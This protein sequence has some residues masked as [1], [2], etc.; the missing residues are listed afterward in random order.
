MKGI[1][2]FVYV[3]FEPIVDSKACREEMLDVIGIL[4]L[5]I[6]D[7]AMLYAPKSYIIQ[8]LKLIVRWYLDKLYKV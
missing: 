2:A 1:K 6:F 3:K 4:E 5:V 7:G 8:V